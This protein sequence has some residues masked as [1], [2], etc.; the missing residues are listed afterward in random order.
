MRWIEVLRLLVLRVERSRHLLLLR[1][2]LLRFEWLGEGCRL[3][4]P[5]RNKW[6]RLCNLNACSR[7]GIMILLLCNIRVCIWVELDDLRRW[8]I[9]SYGFINWLEFLSRD[10]DLS[11]N[12]L[13]LKRSRLSF[14]HRLKFI[15]FCIHKYNS[16]R[17]GWSR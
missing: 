2:L 13:R 9:I 4:D 17:N 7:S 16:M 14:C 10:I 12:L 1:R 8:Q 6:L 15:R 5:L 3:R 11:L